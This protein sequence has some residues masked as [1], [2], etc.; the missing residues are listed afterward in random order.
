MGAVFITLGNNVDLG[1]SPVY[2]RQGEGHADRPDRLCVRL[3]E[4]GETEAVLD[5]GPP[6]QARIDELISYLTRLKVFCS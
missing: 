3:I 1:I 4:Y 6:T 5:L 2:V